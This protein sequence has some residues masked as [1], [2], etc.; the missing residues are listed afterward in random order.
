MCVKAYYILI[1]SMLASGLCAPLAHAHKQH[2]R[3]LSPRTKAGASAKQRE[4]DHN[5]PRTTRVSV[6]RETP[7]SLPHANAGHARYSV[8]HRAPVRVRGVSVGGHPHKHAY[9]PRDR[10]LYRAPEVDLVARKAG[11]ADF[12]TS[13]SANDTNLLL[14]STPLATTKP[15]V[16]R[17]ISRAVPVGDVASVQM[18]LKP[19]V[20]PELDIPP[21]IMRALYAPD[22]RLIVPPALKGSREILVHQNE[23]AELDGLDRVQD[24]DDLDR[25]RASRLLVS[26]PAADGIRWDQRLPV[27]RRY[28]RP[29]TAKFLAELARA[30]YA[31]FHT[32]IQVNSAVRTVEFQQQ[33]IH[34]N[35]NAAP[36]E[37]DT[38]SPHLTGQA[39]D[40]AKHGLSLTEIAWLR[41]YLLPLV[42]E[43]K[44]DVEEEFQQACFHISVYRRYVPQPSPTRS[45]A[46]AS[47]R[48]ATPVLATAI[49]R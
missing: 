3:G 11:P 47:H 13:A 44:V 28:C 22:G 1:V 15:S 5:S 49:P 40:L 17:P 35:G 36:A 27:N 4:H 10:K 37:G 25:M 7:R 8:S 6:G 46:A 33:L 24:D 18:K 38:A 48:G 45:I 12:R 31:R 23:M 2:A 43:G 19:E 34:R 9:V 20:L 26:V 42:Q 32:A 14:E 39:V 30:H 21:V 16:V 29:W 41:G